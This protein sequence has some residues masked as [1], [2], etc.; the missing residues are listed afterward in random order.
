MTITD[1]MPSITETEPWSR[2]AQH[3]DRLAATTLAELFAAEP[4]RG[5]Q[6]SWELDGLW[7]DL[8]RQRMTADTLDLLI[9]LAGA[10]DIE[11]SR[12]AMFGGE[13]IN[14]TEGRAV[15]HAALR[16]DDALTP[17]AEAARARDQRRAMLVFAE[18]V[19]DGT[20][21]GVNGERFGDVVNI[22]I[23]GSHLGPMAATEALQDD[24]GSPRIHYVA[25]VDET[26]LTATL[27]RLDPA[28]TLFLIAS[29]TFTTAET[30]ANA[31]SARA[32]LVAAL[33]ADAVSA[34]FAALSTNSEAAARFGIAPERV[35]GFD[36]WVGGRF[37]LWSS[38]GLSTAIAI[39]GGGFEQLLAG[40]HAMDR[41]FATAPLAENI[42]VILALA[43][44][45]NRNFQNLPARA[46]LPY[47]ERL[48]G[49]PA[50][51]QQLE[52]ESNGKRVTLSGD[53]IDGVPASVVFGMTGT[54]GQ[55]T[56]HQMLHQ[57]PALVA[58]EFIGVA[59]PAAVD[60]ARFGD[61]DLGHHHDMLLANML[62]QAEALALGTKDAPTPHHHCPGDRPSTMILLQR[63]DPNRLGMLLALYEHKVFVEG[64]ILGINSFDQF[65]VELGKTLAGPL[66]EALG[67]GAA[68]PN[69]V[70]AAALAK[71]R[72][73]RR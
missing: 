69:A 37:S 15:L 56:F 5:A 6:M 13:R 14:A 59:E 34:H 55:H 53:A 17:A 25:N 33:G 45:W 31:Q 58:A 9:A 63:L 71:L 7:L 28:R 3:R 24:D 51:L 8:S 4:D 42:P 40:A 50:L 46:V 19:R 30:M 72:A 52:M 23:G 29:K 44:F 60:A 54:N 39:G 49:L 38:V 73:W 21:S 47:D 67:G 70:S 48:R 16:D 1:A 57:G 35:F 20:A 36:E 32:W 22:G 10:R 68:Q 43:D 41:H 18:M 64:A 12:Q 2:L 11:N 65:G 61:S 66:T 27:S 26:D 62:A